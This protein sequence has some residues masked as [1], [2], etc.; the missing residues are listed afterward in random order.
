MTIKGRLAKAEKAKRATTPKEI[1]IWIYDHRDGMHRRYAPGGLLLE[2]LTLAE[3]E[4][5]AKHESA[6][7]IPD[8]G[9]QPVTEIEVNLS[10]AVTATQ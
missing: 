2:C 9:R 3:W 6:I 5:R 4:E 7:S 8:N 1:H 10:Y